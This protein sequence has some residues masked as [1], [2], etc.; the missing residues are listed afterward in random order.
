VAI[1]TFSTLPPETE[2]LMQRSIGCALAVHR[3]LGP[4]FL[5]NVY[6]R[7]L[8]IE[9]EFA[10]ISYERERRLS[11]QYRG[12]PIGAGR[13]DL[14]VGG[15]VVIEIKAVTNLDPVFQ[16]QLLSYLKATGLRAG[17]LINFNAALLKHGIKRVVL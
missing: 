3:Q 4:G 10:G 13:V 6:C 1:A 15:A 11:L 12:R 2:L 17:L 14:I 5:E 8:C 7:A 9:F 16:A